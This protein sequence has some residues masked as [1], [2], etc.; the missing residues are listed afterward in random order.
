MSI[1]VEILVQAPIDAL[2]AH[3]QTPELHERWE[4]AIA[5]R[6][7]VAESERG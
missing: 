2:W 6:G 3:T 1:Y 4:G 7:R 5:L